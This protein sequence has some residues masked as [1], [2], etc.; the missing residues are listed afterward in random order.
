MDRNFL[1]IPGVRDLL[2]CD[3]GVNISV[4]GVDDKPCPKQAVMRL[5][6]HQGEESAMFQFC[7]G[8][9]AFVID[10]STPRNE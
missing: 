7:E 5:V 8:H 9:Y 10:W 6:I 3:F 2:G 1:E 4:P